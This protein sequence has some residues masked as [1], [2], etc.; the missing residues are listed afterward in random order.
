MRQNGGFFVQNASRRAYRASLM[1][2][3]SGLVGLKSENVETVL[4]LQHFLKGQGSPEHS[5]KT[6]NEA[7]RSGWEGVGGG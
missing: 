4:V 5:T 3:C 7:R 6:N 2:I 1:C